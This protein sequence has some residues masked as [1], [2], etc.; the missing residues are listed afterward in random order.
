MIWSNALRFYDPYQEG[1]RTNCKIC[2]VKMLSPKIPRLFMW[3][4]NNGYICLD[5]AKKELEL[6]KEKLEEYIKLLDDPKYSTIIVS[7]GL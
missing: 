2:K 5:C 7:E 3:G 4:F 1:H 6:Y